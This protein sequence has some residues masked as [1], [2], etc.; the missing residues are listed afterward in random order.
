[1]EL[2]DRIA[3]LPRERRS[4]I[5]IA[6]PP[7][8]GKSSFADELE[9][10]LNREEGGSTAVLPMDGYHFDDM[11]LEARGHR[12][13]KGA[14]HTF[15][16]DG[17]KAMLDRLR[18]D[19]GRDVVVPVFDRALEIARAGARV[20]PGTVRRV[21]VEGNYLLLDDPDW[22]PLRTCFDLT[23]MLDVPWDIIEQRLVAR[24]QGFN[25]DAQALRAKMEGN[26]LPN[27]W[28]VREH[29]VAADLV[30]PNAVPRT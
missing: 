23:V 1:M 20:I 8:A 6:G 3:G 10:R 19:D 13:R 14:P 22:A 15:D 28:L 25:Y 11:L 4:L 17:L 9:S 29:S 18:L 30:V 27:V 24:W 12:A 2:L 21:I 7:G 5:A 26:D 16:V